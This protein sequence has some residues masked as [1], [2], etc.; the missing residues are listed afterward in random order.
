M[1][2]YNYN[3]LLPPLANPGGL[4]GART[5]KGFA[6]VPVRSGQILLNLELFLLESC[7][8]DYFFF[9]KWRSKCFNTGLT[10]ASGMGCDRWTQHRA[11]KGDGPFA[12]EKMG[13]GEP[14]CV[15]KGM[16]CLSFP[17]IF[18]FFFKKTKS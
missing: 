9:Y 16:N 14:V 11:S 3:V 1:T 17:W 12:K 5:G 8:I 13:W 15:S 2:I 6:S 4:Q 10:T 18:S 7:C